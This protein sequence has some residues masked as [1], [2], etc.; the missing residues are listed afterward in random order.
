VPIE[1]RLEDERG[2]IV[3]VEDPNGGSCDGA[4]GFDRLL[5]LDDASYRCLGVVDPYGDTVFNRLQMP[6]LLDDL[7][8]LDLSSANDAE[9]RGLLRLEALARRCGEGTHLYLRFIGD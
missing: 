8:R 2:N 9:R 5:P 7:A 3:A 4:G 6:F 1:V